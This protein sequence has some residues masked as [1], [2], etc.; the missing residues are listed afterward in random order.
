MSK[1]KG[2]ETP[3]GKTQQLTSKEKRKKF[4]IKH[5][6]KKQ[7]SQKTLNKKN[8]ENPGA[9][10][11]APPQDPQQFSSNWKALQEVCLTN[12]KL[13]ALHKLCNYLCE[14]VFTFKM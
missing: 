2:K 6:R 14:N 9:K 10:Q 13:Y 11:T 8:L 12:I 1:I 5:N 4:F 7:T 3:A